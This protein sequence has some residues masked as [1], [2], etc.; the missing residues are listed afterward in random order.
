[1][2]ELVDD[3]DELVCLRVMEK[4]STFA[5]SVQ[6]QAKRYREEAETL[7]EK[8][9]GTNL[10]NRAINLT[11]EYAVGTVQDVIQDLVSVVL[12]GGV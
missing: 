8:I 9:Q 2:Q 4:D 11:L 5:T 6:T 12:G 7:M 1:V 10:E 3:G